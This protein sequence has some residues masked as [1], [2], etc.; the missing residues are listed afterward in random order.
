M[1]RPFPCGRLI[2]FTFPICYDGLEWA[3]SAPRNPNGGAIRHQGG[4]FVDDEDE[5]YD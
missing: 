4:G 1:A 5:Y 3:G 2:G